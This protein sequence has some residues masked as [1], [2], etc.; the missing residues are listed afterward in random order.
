MR[1]QTPHLKY[2]MESENRKLNVCVDRKVI[3][4]VG[5][6]EGAVNMRLQGVRRDR[7]IIWTWVRMD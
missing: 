4:Q 1:M 7:K 2:L 3:R 6:I 5:D